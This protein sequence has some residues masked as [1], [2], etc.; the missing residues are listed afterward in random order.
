MYSTLNR[1]YA[2]L[3]AWSR[4]AIA[5][6]APRLHANA[7]ARRRQSSARLR[8]ERLNLCQR[9]LATDR[10]AAYQQHAVPGDAHRRIPQWVVVIV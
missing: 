6:R 4:N 3:A 10:G 1:C 5:H 9:A 7:P 8:D 2:R